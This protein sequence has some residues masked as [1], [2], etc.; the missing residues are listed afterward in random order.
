MSLAGPRIGFTY[1]VCDGQ[2][3]NV[4]GSPM[5]CLAWVVTRVFAFSHL[6]GKTP[7]NTVRIRYKVPH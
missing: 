4:F 2:R 5:R 7:A 6:R 1:G 3:I